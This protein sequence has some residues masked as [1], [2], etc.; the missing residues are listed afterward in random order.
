MALNDLVTMPTASRMCRMS[1]L[2][3]M[4]AG[5]VLLVVLQMQRTLAMTL[6]RDNHDI[7]WNISN[8]IFDR[9]NTDHVIDIQIGDK[10]NIICPFWNQTDPA[11]YPEYHSLYMVTREQYTSCRLNQHNSREHRWIFGCTQPTEHHVYSFLITPFSPHP[12]GFEFQPG[13]DYYIISPSSGFQEG[14]EDTEG[15]LCRSMNMKMVFRVGCIDCEEEETSLTTRHP[16]LI[17]EAGTFDD[18]TSAETN[19]I[20]EGVDYRLPVYETISDNQVGS[21]DAAG[22]SSSTKRETTHGYI[23]NVI[24]AQRLVSDANGGVRRRWV[25]VLHALLPLFHALL[26]LRFLS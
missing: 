1:A 9:S 16:N 14:L 23:I 24:K 6:S 18:S 15:G 21:G 19:V 12:W 17:P 4:S 2:W 22:G 11:S 20:P 26:V 25:G 13:T 10:V 8:P 3:R 5:V 7:Y